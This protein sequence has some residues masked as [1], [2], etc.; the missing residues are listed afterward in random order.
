[1]LPSVSDALIGDA[2]RVRQIVTN[3]VSNAFKFTHEGEVVLKAE[4]MPSS[5]DPASG[6]VALQISVRDTRIG[7]S[8]Y[9]EVTNLDVLRETLRGPN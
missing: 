5:G 9:D 1:M 8:V 3:L 2:L 4:T 6:R 7:I